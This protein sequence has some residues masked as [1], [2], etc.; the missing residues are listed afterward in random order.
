MIFLK[1]QFESEILQLTYDILVE[2]N[3]SLHKLE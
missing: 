1:Y 2:Y 3:E